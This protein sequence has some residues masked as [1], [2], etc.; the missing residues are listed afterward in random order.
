MPEYWA[1][2]AM[3]QR[4]YNPK[5][6]K[7]KDYGKRGIVVCRRWRESFEDFFADMGPRPPG[8]QLE[9]SNNDGDYK[10]RNCKWATRSQQQRNTR[11]GRWT[12][13]DGRKNHVRGHA[14]AR[15]IPESTFRVSLFG[16]KGNA[17]ACRR[18]R[19]RQREH[20]NASKA[21]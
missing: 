7:F 20:H 15:G 6:P 18:Y 14:R 10:P 16:R 5:H 8:H 1:W 17:E 9:R 21:T 2:K 13:I 4:C 19:E 11:R 12:V 3:K